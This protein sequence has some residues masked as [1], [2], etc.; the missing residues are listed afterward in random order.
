LYSY[1]EEKQPSIYTIQI[2]TYVT[3]ERAQKQF[4]QLADKLD[5]HNRDY[6]R[7]ERVKQYFPLRLGLFKG[8]MEAN[9]FLLTVKSAIPSAIVVKSVFLDERIE[10]MYGL[11][12]EAE[13]EKPLQTTLP[14]VEDI[15]PRHE[16]SPEVA[17]GKE[18]ETAPVMTE[19]ES[20]SKD[21][22]VEDKIAAINN[23]IY[24]NDY[25]SALEIIKNEIK[26]QPYHLE[27]NALYGAVLLRTYRPKEAQQYLKKAVELSPST[28]DYHNGLGYCY[29]YLDEYGKAIESFKQAVSLEP[30]HIDALAG[31]GLIFARKGNKE[32]SLNYYNRLKKLDTDSAE[33]LLKIIEHE[34]Q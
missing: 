10:Q 14:K 18:P 23:L 1:A 29:F 11:Q 5:P 7:I 12:K 30:D 13:E 31:L 22:P 33:K 25:E 15:K 34:K 24:I 32:E 8:K 26:E 4:Q 17:A 9:E 27:L 2:A 28:P 3:L 16:S 20:V 6:L 21:I 19:S